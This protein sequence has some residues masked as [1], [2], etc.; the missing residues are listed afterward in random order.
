ML[1]NLLKREE[2]FKPKPYEDTEGILTIGYGFTYI[3]EAEASVILEGRAKE[4]T[5][6]CRKEFKWFPSLTRDRQEV[7]A[8]M[9]YQLGLRGF[10]GFKKMIKAIEVG[11]FLTAANEGLDSRWARQTPDRA[12]RHM[13][14]LK[15]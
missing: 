15:G 6:I 12:T 2:G 4:V 3:T 1:V 11:D 7:I 8:S 14:V 9:V 13:E 5:R 10:K